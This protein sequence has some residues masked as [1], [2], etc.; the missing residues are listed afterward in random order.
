VVEKTDWV[1]IGILALLAALLAVGAL[2]V[3]VDIV[4]DAAADRACGVFSVDA[5]WSRGGK[6]YAACGDGEIV[7]FEALEP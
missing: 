2:G 6:L 1:E 5:T 3:W 4:V 7:T